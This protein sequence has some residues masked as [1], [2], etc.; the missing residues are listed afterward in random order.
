VLR[1]RR[2]APH[3]LLGLLLAALAAAPAARAGSGAAPAPDDAHSG[4]RRIVSLNPSLTETLLALGAGG[5][6]V[7]VDEWSARR[8]P[9][10]RDLPKVGGLFNPSLEGVAALAPDLVVAVPSAA[11]R[12][13]RRRVEALGVEVL[14]LPNSTLEELLASIVTLGRRVDR[15]CAARRRVA[16]IRETFARVERATAGRAQSRVVLVLTR[17]PL[18]V[19]GSGS[20]LD[21]ML[22]AAGAENAAGE[23][24]DPYPRVGEE[25]L[26]DRAPDVILDAS[27]DPAPAPRYWA[28]WPSLP[29]VRGGR[30][31]ELEPG[32]VAFPGPDLDVALV[33]LARLLH[34]S[35]LALPDPADAGAAAGAR[36]ALP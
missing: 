27:Q 7:G 24:S 21:A 36:G 10:V 12:D 1:P 16:A 34:G 17:D 35:D 4:A 29:A 22:A 11:Q 3:W 2:A 6:L 19:V 15:A 25:W 32:R 9:A 20:F 5:R 13:F 8:A 23:F 14:E 28:R 30:V 26:V 31:L 18:Y 33:E